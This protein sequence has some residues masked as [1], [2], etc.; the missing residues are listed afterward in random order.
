MTAATQFIETYE[1]YQICL[2][3]LASSMVRGELPS[4]EL[5]H[6]ARTSKTT[7]EPALDLLWKTLSNPSP[8]LRLLPADACELV[9]GKY[10]LK[11]PLIESDFEAFD[12]YAYRVRILDFLEPNRRDTMGCHLFAALRAH[13]NPIFPRLS[14][15]EWSMEAITAGSFHILSRSAPAERLLLTSSSLLTLSDADPPDWPGISAL[16]K[17][18]LASWIPDVR[19]LYLGGHVHELFSP[20]NLLG[21]LKALTKLQHLTLQSPV[22]PRILAHL[23]A[24]PYLLSLRLEQEDEDCATELQRVFYDRQRNHERSFPALEKLQV[25]FCDYNTLCVLIGL[26][27]S[28]DL[29][30]LGFTL[31]P[32]HPID[33]SLLY[34]LMSPDPI[35]SLTRGRNLRD[36][37]VYNPHSTVSTAVLEWLYSCPCLETLRVYGEIYPDDADIERMVSSWPNLRTLFIHNNS[38]LP[39]RAHLYS[40][41]SLAARCPNLYEICMAVDARNH[42]TAITTVDADFQP[43]PSYTARQIFLS[44]S[45]IEDEDIAAVADFLN[46][47]F[48]HLT[49]FLG[50]G[51]AWEEVRKSLHSLP[52]DEM[53]KIL[54]LEEE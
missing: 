17:D 38:E 13:R 35:L 26:V 50:R 32:S 48:P 7:S 53:G 1:L 34:P 18:P 44:D 4:R 2:A 31:N 33:S 42:A 47:T 36:I 40:L 52:R 51:P 25:I 37:Y 23:A 41:R 16:V 15:F 30:T 28:I 5:A 39:P 14:T 24:L 54:E 9:Q 19:D 27:D 22:G 8:I 20:A 6:L 12:K 29:H 3:F 10:M 46:D 43:A 11:R 49:A 45:L 21:G